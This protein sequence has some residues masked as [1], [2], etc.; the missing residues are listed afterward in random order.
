MNDSHHPS[1]AFKLSTISSPADPL[2][3]HHSQLWEIFQVGLKTGRTYAFA[4]C[5]STIYDKRRKINA[6]EE[7]NHTNSKTL[8]EVLGKRRFTSGAEFSSAISTLEKDLRDPIQQVAFNRD[9]VSSQN[10]IKLSR[11]EE[12]MKELEVS[13]QLKIDSLVERVTSLEKENQ[14]IKTLLERESEHRQAL[15]E[16]CRKTLDKSDNVCCLCKR[17]PLPDFLH[18]N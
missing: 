12:R 8:Y 6:E 18:N 7:M 17:T 11:L 1:S 10:I 4:E 15:T 5:C 13:S 3:P 2:P 16:M 9:H 14:S